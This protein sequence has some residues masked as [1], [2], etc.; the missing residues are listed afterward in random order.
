MIEKFPCT[1]IPTSHTLRQ[2]AHLS[3][4]APEIIYGIAVHCCYVWSC[5]WNPTPHPPTDHLQQFL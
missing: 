2:N 5:T 3:D 1:S 4:Q